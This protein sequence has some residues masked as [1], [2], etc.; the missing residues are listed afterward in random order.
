MTKKQNMEKKIPEII[1][2]K[3]NLNK[4]KAKCNRFI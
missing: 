3:K 4:L 1:F 2:F